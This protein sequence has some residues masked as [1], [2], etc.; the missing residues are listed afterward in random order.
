MQRLYIY[1]FEYSTG[2]VY[3][4]GINRDQDPVNVLT[5]YGFGVGDCHYMV[6]ERKDIVI[7]NN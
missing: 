2:T 1:V 4:F 5:D 3:R 6:T 7:P